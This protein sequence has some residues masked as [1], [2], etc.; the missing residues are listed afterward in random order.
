MMQIAIKC[1]DISNPTKNPLL[2]QKWATKV[3]EEFY[4]Q[5]DEERRQEMPVSAFMDRTK[6]AEAKCQI[7]FID[8]IVSPLFDVW[9]SFLPDMQIALENLEANRTFWKKK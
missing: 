7:G 4:R 9:T 8:F 1:S 5:G 2:C 3:M 6:P